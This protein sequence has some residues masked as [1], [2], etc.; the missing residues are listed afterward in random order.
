MTLGTAEILDGCTDLILKAS[1]AVLAIDRS[2]VR[3]RAK[4]DLSP[5]TAADEISHS[6]MMRGLAELCP[7]LVVVS[8]EADRGSY[9]RDLG[10][11]FVLLDPIDGTREY[12]AGRAE[13]T[14]NVALV[15]G[16]VPTIGVIAAPALGLIWR[17]RR[18]AGA[19]RT[20]VDFNHGDRPSL[21]FTRIHTRKAP[22]EN[23]I[24]TFSRSHFD[25]DTA[26]F[27]ARVPVG[28]RVACGSSLKFCRIAEGNADVYPRLAPTSEWDIAAGHAL[29]TAAGGA[30][31]TVDG[32]PITY[33]N[34]AQGF[35]VPAFIAWGDRTMIAPVRDR[36]P[37]RNSE[38]PESAK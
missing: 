37:S 31:T 25:A 10:H 17:G 2:T 11:S 16:G 28:E 35:K 1:A 34:V 36:L 33:G 23:W 14:I 13:Y 6:V 21:Q 19:E 5:V 32:A 12:L 3:Q 4:A 30:V 27:L 20:R 9:A 8:E 26:A 15:V 18:D 7:G 22:A 38:K 29:L 24:A